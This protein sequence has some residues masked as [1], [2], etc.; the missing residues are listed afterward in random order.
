MCVLT[1]C[2][3]LQTMREVQHSTE[4][5]LQNYGTRV[6]VTPV[7]VVK[8]KDGIGRGA[9][10]LPPRQLSCEVFGQ[11]P[12]EPA[13]DDVDN[14]KNVLENCSMGKMTVQPGVPNEDKYLAPGVVEVT[15]SLNTATLTKKADVHDK[16]TDAGERGA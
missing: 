15:I 1:N 10:S 4:R 9:V 6:G 3:S 12:G 5:R 7:L 16:V 8:V 2:V 14:L 13:C 11:L